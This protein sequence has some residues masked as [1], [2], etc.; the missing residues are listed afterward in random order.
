MR[1]RLRRGRQL[2]IRV[3]SA[4]THGA[5]GAV[6]APGPGGAGAPRVRPGPGARTAAGDDRG[7]PAPDSA[8]LLVA[9]GVVGLL[10][11][12]LALQPRLLPVR[13]AA[14]V[15]A[16]GS[17]F[18]AGAAA[19]NVYFGYFA[20]WADVRAE[21]TGGSGGV[22][23]PGAPARA[24][25]PA[26]ERS[27]PAP[28]AAGGPA[29]SAP[30]PGSRPG[31]P[32]AGVTPAGVPAAGGGTLVALVL[33]GR[34]S[35][36]DRTGLVWLPPQYGQPAY[37]RTRFP[38]V[39]LIPGS[40]GQ[41]ADW[42][43]H[44][45]VDRVLAALT[46][47]GRIR[48]MVVVLAPSNPPLHHGHSEECTDKGTRGAQDSTYLGV[49]V[50][51]DVLAA[52]R[53]QR[54]GPHWAIGGYSSGGYCATDLTL[55]HPGTYGAV[56]DLDGYLSP[57][58]DGNLWH[59]IFNRDRAALLRYDIRAELARDHRRLPPFYLEAGRADR[60]D[61]RDLVTLRALL[62]GRAAVTAHLTPGGHTYAVWEAELPAVF[63]WVSHRIA[64]GPA[65]V[66]V[67]AR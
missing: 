33:A 42:I 25:T 11:L 35:H 20:S 65:A 29:T 7:V 23:K 44:L 31:S 14:A 64:P 8:G 56:V 22:P 24:R 52:F 3:T 28:T 38:V 17:V 36:L 6:P 5:G 58:E 41:P 27:L 48:P 9:L 30:L 18:V 62:R 55:K 46:A 1:L 15:L 4:P 21:I 50:P 34:R 45:H 59:V 53:V 32:P 47:S 51:A 2:S 26:V 63:T 43:A 57:L 66:T 13:I 12:A 37:A 67:P 49:D 61:V 40:P 54:P 19:V 16:L 10:A 39:E 60:E